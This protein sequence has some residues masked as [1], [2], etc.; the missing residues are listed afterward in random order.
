MMKTAKF[1]HQR[2]TL[3]YICLWEI[4]ISVSV[5]STSAPEEV[6][7]GA[8]G[9][10]L[11]FPTLVPV[12]GAI[13][14]EGRTIGQVFNKQ[15]ETGITEEFKNRLHWDSQSGFF[16]LSDLRTDDS[17][18]YI[19]E[20][21]KEVKSKQ[22]YQLNVYDKVSAPQVIKHN[23]SS[24]ESDLCSLQCS[25]RNVRGLNLFWFKGKS[26]L[27]HTNS[28]SLNN[29]LNLLLEIEK[30]DNDPYSCMATNPVSN[31]TTTVHITELC[32]HKPGVDSGSVSRTHI[33]TIIIC[34]AVDIRDDCV[35]T[36]KE[37]YMS[38]RKTA[39]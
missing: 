36:E 21:T 8:V 13:L 19:V 6:L 9:K 2:W 31:Q 14:Y 15:T 34:T 37:I 30:F 16:T 33:F 17:G 27:N 28:S 29:T 10:S 25:V 35:C 39:N 38:A 11:T 20:S 1:H 18:V 7:N 3:L 22:A 32:H 26:L 4:F 12:T 5:S 23:S 24:A